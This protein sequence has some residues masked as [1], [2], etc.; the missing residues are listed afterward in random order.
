LT[1][2]FSGHSRTDPGKYRPEGE[3]DLWKERDPIAAFKRRLIEEGWED[4]AFEVIEAQ[5]ETEVQQAVDRAM[6]SPVPDDAEML[7]DVF[8]SEDQSW[9]N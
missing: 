6:A 3:L 9:R 8:C 7:T 2:R 5:V 4:S 1:Y